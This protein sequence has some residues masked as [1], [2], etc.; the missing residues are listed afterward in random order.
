MGAAAGLIGGDIG[1]RDFPF[2][3]VGRG[4]VGVGIIV[5]VREETALG[6]LVTKIKRIPSHMASKARDE[7]IYLLPSPDFVSSRTG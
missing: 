6:D 4:F 3:V 7:L 1:D 5:G 2:E